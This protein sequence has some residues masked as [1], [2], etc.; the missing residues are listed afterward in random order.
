MLRQARPVPFL[1]PLELPQPVQVAP[2][3]FQLVPVEVAMAEMLLS[4]LET[5]QAQMGKVAPWFWLQGLAIQVGVSRSA[6]VLGLVP[7]RVTLKLR[8]PLQAP[9]DLAFS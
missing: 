7:A 3:C 1:S 5:A 9:A 8:R 2:S 6:A 4:H